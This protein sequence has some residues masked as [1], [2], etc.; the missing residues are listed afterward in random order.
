[1]SWTKVKA[2]AL[3]RRP[4]EIL[5]EEE[6]VNSLRDKGLA[7]LLSQDVKNRN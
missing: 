4:N 5:N 6:N 3:S 2:G 1:M 7:K